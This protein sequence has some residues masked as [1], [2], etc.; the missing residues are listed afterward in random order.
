M[1]A[2]TSSS[3]GGAGHETSVSGENGVLVFKFRPNMKLCTLYHSENKKEL[4]GI[5]IQKIKRRIHAELQSF[6]WS[7]SLKTF[8][9]LPSSALSCVEQ[10]RLTEEW[11]EHS[12]D[13]AGLS[14]A[15]KLIVSVLVLC[16]SW[17][18]SDPR[19]KERNDK[20]LYWGRWWGYLSVINLNVNGKIL[21][22]S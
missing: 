20:I 17:T 11:R 13:P 1:T 8:R 19:Q 5:L 15:M 18:Q 2:S 9:Y 10:D 3:G 7:V 21:P 6:G 4:L 16:P 12:L 22:S 14:G